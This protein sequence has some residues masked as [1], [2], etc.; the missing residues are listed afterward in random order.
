MMRLF[1]I[2][3]GICLGTGSVAQEV[4][5][6]CKAERLCDE[7]GHCQKVSDG[8]YPYGAKMR[9]TALAGPQLR[10]ITTRAAKVRVQDVARATGFFDTLSGMA[11]QHNGFL[12]S[13]TS[14]GFMMTPHRVFE[15]L[16]ATGNVATGNPG[17]FTVYGPPCDG[18]PE[19][20]S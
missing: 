5:L 10:D 1:T 2:A 4:R 9:I 13:L 18:L 17:A 6:S 7:A 8:A 16:D 15:Y 19:G 3:L 12:F 11:A 20:D 14:N